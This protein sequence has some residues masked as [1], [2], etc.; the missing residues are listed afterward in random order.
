MSPLPKEYSPTLP[1]VSSIVEFAY[2]FKGEDKERFLSW[3][4]KKNIEFEDYMEEASYWGRYV[5]NALEKYIKTGE[6]TGKKYRWYVLNGISFLKTGAYEV[7]ETEHYVRGRDY[8]WTIDIIV[9]RVSDGKYW[10]LDYKTYGLAKDKFGI[11]KVYRKPY[12]KLKKASLQLSLYSR[13]VKKYKIE[14]IGI[15]E[16]WEDYV[17]EHPLEFWEEE[18]IKKLIKEYK[19]SYIDNI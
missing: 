19:L 16:L 4:W 7:V 1:R 5:H 10:I 15:V 3:L 8:Q 9:R 13:I 12:D 2:P 17:F 11:E 14:F 18:D 6:F